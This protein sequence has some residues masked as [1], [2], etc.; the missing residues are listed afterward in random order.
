MRQKLNL[1][2]VSCISLFY[3]PLFSRGTWA[4]HAT[5]QVQHYKQSGLHSRLSIYCLRRPF[6]ASRGATAGLLGNLTLWQEDIC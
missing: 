1:F 2:T 6:K 5:L 3:K 4:G